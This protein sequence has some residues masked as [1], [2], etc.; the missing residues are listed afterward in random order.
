[1]KHKYI[2]TAVLASLIILS[3]CLKGVWSG[4]IYFAVSFLALLSLYWGAVLIYKY[5]DDYKWQFEEDF[6]Y[7]KAQ[8]INSTSIT[9]KDF[10]A[11]RALYVKKFKRTLVRDKIIDIF[12][13]LFCLSM[14][15]IC[16]V[17]LCSGVIR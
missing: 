4:F 13:I 9:E 11:A 15:V 14:V 3:G 6:A 5:I 7:Y 10:E 16:I 17:A 8:T 2:V 1:M 12:K